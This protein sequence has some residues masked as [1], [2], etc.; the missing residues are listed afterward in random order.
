MKVTVLG[1]YGPYP[2]AGGNCSGYLLEGNK[3]KILMDCGNGTFSQ[4]QKYTNYWEIDAIV[5]SHLHMDHV[6]DCFVARYAFESA[7]AREKRKLP[8]D[9]HTLTEPQEVY[10]LLGHKNVFH[11]WPIKP[12]GEIELGD[13]RLGF[14]PTVH[15]K[16]CCAIKVEC[17]NKVLVYSADTEY[18]EGLV[19]FIRG[20]DLFICESSYLSQ[21]L[22]YDFYNH[23][24]SFQAGQLARKGQVKRLKLTHLHPE[25]PEDIL[26]SEAKAEFENTELVKEGEVIEVK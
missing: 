5:L 17:N 20:S 7:I 25:K 19:D 11:T 18:F 24:A 14:L 3:T 26:L 6:S 8:L 23:M 4:L 13:L 1:K 16:I 22:E 21:D 15:S 9:I 10:G 2:P 12:Y